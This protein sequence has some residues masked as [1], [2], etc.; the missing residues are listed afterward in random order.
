M[1]KYLA[2]SSAE[3]TCVTSVPQLIGHGFLPHRRRILA[4]SRTTVCI[5][6]PPLQ[7][8]RDAIK[9]HKAQKHR[10]CCRRLGAVVNTA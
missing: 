4:P 6:S 10:F 5:R 2:M 1:V 8:L 9:T 3:H 7:S